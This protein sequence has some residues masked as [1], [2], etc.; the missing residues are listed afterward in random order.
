[1]NRMAY[2]SMFSL[3][4][5]IFSDVYHLLMVNGGKARD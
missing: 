3:L 5:D 1:M 2:G 4:E